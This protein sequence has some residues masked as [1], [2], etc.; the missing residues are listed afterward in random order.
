M[1]SKRICCNAT[2]KFEMNSHHESFEGVEFFGIIESNFLGSL[3]NVY[4]D[5]EENSQR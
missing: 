2:S 1:S 4:S 5:G 3:Y